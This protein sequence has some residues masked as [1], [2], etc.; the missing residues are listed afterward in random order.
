[1][2]NLAAL[3]D[4]LEALIDKVA[5]HAASLEDAAQD[6]DTD[7]R[8]QAELRKVLLGQGLASPDPMLAPGAVGNH[9]NALVGQVIAALTSALPALGR[10]VDGT[11]QAVQGVAGFNQELPTLARAAVPGRTRRGHTPARSVARPGDRYD[12][13]RR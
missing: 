12:G 7:G 8:V 13:A 4:Q 1:M 11:S 3:R 9:V 5:A 10:H 6:P 2:P